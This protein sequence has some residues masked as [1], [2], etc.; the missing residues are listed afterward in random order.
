MW[1]QSQRPICSEHVKVN[2]IMAEEM[3]L[4]TGSLQQFLN[5]TQ[6]HLWCLFAISFILALLTAIFPVDLE[7]YRN[8]N[9]SFWWSSVGQQ[10]NAIDVDSVGGPPGSP[11]GF[12]EIKQFFLSKTHFIRKLVSGC[13]QFK[14]YSVCSGSRRQKRRKE[15]IPVCFFLSVSTFF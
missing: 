6:D 14:I 7:I 4:S 5:V 12:V 11:A 8:G 15:I 1:Q 9:T 10:I 13:I 2:D 3:V